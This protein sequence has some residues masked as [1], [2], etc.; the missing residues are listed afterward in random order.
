MSVNL[1][2]I[3][4]IICLVYHEARNVRHPAKSGKLADA[5]RYGKLINLPTNRDDAWRALDDLRTRAA[6]SGSVQAAVKSFE[7]TFGLGPED[8]RS[9]YAMPI[10]KG[11]ACGGNKWAD[12]SARVCDFV[13]SS[14][15]DGLPDDA[16]YREILS[17]SHNTGKVSEKLGRLKAV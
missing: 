12:I 3:V 5:S 16:L 13:A 6:A 9:L 10:W 11:S 8:L 2:D 4:D 17:M 7:Q 14:T 15:A 1:P